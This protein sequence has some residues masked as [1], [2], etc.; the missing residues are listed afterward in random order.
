M[1]NSLNM[2]R[3]CVPGEWASEW[4]KKSR[5]VTKLTWS[6]CVV[7][8]WGDKGPTNAGSISSYIDW[9]L[10]GFWMSSIVSSRA[11]WHEVRGNRSVWFRLI[12]ENTL[13]TI[14]ANP[15]VFEF[16]EHLRCRCWRAFHLRSIDRFGLSRKKRIMIWIYECF[17]MWLCVSDNPN[18]K[19]V[20]SK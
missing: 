3:V 12:C 1:W 9:E 7:C 16:V 18:A 2:L 17:L 10:L 19:S 20:F 11:Y 15:W 14:S 6:R 13:C 8:A 4:V 5:N